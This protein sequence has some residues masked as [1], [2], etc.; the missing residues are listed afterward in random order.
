MMPLGRNVVEAMLVRGYNFLREEPLERR[1][2][3]SLALPFFVRD[4]NTWQIKFCFNY[5]M[6]FHKQGDGELGQKSSMFL[7]ILVFLSIFLLFNHSL[8]IDATCI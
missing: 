6:L 2:E 3:W 8:L 4:I 1:G 7:A 5:S